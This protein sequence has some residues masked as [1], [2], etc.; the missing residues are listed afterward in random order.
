MPR[1]EVG[2]GPDIGAA[3]IL[4]DGLAQASVLL[5]LFAVRAKPARRRFPRLLCG[6]GGLLARGLFANARFEFREMRPRVG[7]GLQVQARRSGLQV[8][9][10][11]DHVLIQLR[12]DNGLAR[13]AGSLDRLPVP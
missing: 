1:G 6:V 9:G 7:V 4:G 3:A 12:Y 11:D 5:Q 10:V 8:G 2:V 13:C